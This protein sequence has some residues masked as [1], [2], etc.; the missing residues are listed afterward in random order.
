MVD[1]DNECIVIGNSCS[2]DGID[3]KLLTDMGLKAYNFSLGGATLKT[4]YIQLSTYLEYNEAPA[5]VLLG[6]SPNSRSQFD[7]IDV[8][9]V[10][11]FLYDDGNGL[12]IRD[13][14][15][16]KFKWL[17][18]EL[19]KKLF[20]SDHRRVRLERGHFKTE[21]TIPDNSVYNSKN[22]IPQESFL[23]KYEN[24]TYLSNLDSICKIKKI[25]LLLIE[26]PGSKVNQND[27]GVGPI[28][29]KSFDGKGMALY[30]LNDHNFCDSLF[31]D[32]TDWLSEDHLNIYGAKKLTNYLSKELLTAYLN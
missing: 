31:N 26:L 23:M 4:S 2:M 18:K 14:P 27:Y 1:Q 13:I 24:S 32:S 11:D 30:N 20:S 9:P 21:R 29:F 16:I 12:S 6:L 22:T 25:E 10:V 19:L 28:H 15:V 3:T 17:G 7:P 5:L 8:H